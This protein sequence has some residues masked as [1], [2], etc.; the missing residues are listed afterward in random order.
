MLPSP[1]PERPAPRHATGPASRR[2]APLHSAY[3]IYRHPTY[4]TR[5]TAMA[6]KPS[7][8]STDPTSDHRGSVE[9]KTVP[10]SSVGLSLTLS[11]KALRDFDRKQEE[12]IKA[13]EKDRK[14]SWR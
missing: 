2:F 9:R 5:R 10:A 1:K 12:T 14:F 7:D 8:P 4:N 3:T 11:N 6:T 13:A